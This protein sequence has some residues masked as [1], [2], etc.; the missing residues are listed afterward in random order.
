MS[1][2]AAGNDDSS[3]LYQVEPRE[4]AG[5]VTGLRYDFQYHQAA[6]DALQVLDDTDVACV[7]CEWH[8]DYVIE[9]AGPVS[10]RFHQVKTRSA[11]QG[12]WRINEFFGLS[13]KRGRKKTGAPSPL[14]ASTDSIFAR[15]FDHTVRFGRRCALFVFVSDAGMSTEFEDLLRGVQSVESISQLDAS[16][17]AEFVRIFDAIALTFD[18]IT[19]ELFFA[20]LQRLRIRAAV[21]SLASIGD[22]RTL[23]GGRILQLSEVDLTQSQS[24]KIGSD[25]VAAVRERSHRVLPIMPQSLE[26]LREAKGLVIEDVLKLL[27][28]SDAGYRELKTGGRETVIALSRLH[29]LLDRSGL[30]PT[31]IPQLCRLKAAWDAWWV[32][33]RHVLNSLDVIAL[34]SECAAALVVHAAGNLDFMGLRNEA[35]SIADKF[36]PMLTSTEPLSD[37]LVF[38]LLLSISVEAER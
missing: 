31:E 14:S 11:S 2:Y 5:P 1:D 26:A 28:L 33:Q 25:L 19:V 34:R 37:E 9:A 38:G 32:T 16:V 18:S 3:E 35:R 6:A 24:Q 20:F 10:Y 23:I 8:D 15:F 7:Y 12:P 13:G 4:Q 17:R 29:R 27:S 21:G 36:A 22:C 30:P